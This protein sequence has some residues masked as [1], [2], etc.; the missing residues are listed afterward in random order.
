MTVYS[1]PETVT[2]LDAE[3]YKE[4]FQTQRAHVIVRN[5]LKLMNGQKLKP[6]AV[7]FPDGMIPDGLG[8]SAKRTV[9]LKGLK[10]VP[11]NGEED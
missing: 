4:T 8:Y 9:V 2:G 1:V 10:G 3:L 7:A 11:D 6:G 5:T